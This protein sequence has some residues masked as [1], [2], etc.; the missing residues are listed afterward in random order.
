[1]KKLITAILVLVLVCQ[2]TA[3]AFAAGDAV[4]IRFSWWGDEARHNVTLASIEKFEAAYPNIKIEPE[5]MGWD[6]Y[7]TKLKTQIAGGSAPDVMQTDV[8][9]MPGIVSQGKVFYDL[10]ALQIDRSGFDAKFV[11]NWGTQ[12]GAI[13]GLPTGTNGETSIFNA[14]MM[15]K[16]SIPM[17]QPLSWNDILE[18]GKKLKEQFPDS[19]MML[20]DPNQ[21]EL[22]ILNA[23]ICQ[24]IGTGKYGPGNIRN[25][26]EEDLTEALTYIDELLAAEVLVPFEQSSVHSVNQMENPL[27]LTGKVAMYLNFTTHIASAQKNSP[28]EIA[29]GLF[30]SLEGGK[31]SGIIVQ[32]AQL[33]TISANT[34]HPEEAALFVDFFFNNPDSQVALGLNRSVPAVQS[35]RELLASRGE[36]N[37]VLNEAVNR[38]LAN[39]GETFDVLTYNGEL[40][41]ILVTAVE[42]VGYDT[43]TPAEAAANAIKLIDAKLAEF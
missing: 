31:Q 26:S 19:Y 10:N 29:T 40:V 6:G 35:A 17:D 18:Y 5:Y 2:L 43:M 36:L 34:Q 42:A 8:K 1:M 33:I 13:I 22:H 28:F 27:W 14:E 12:D 3:V 21:V 39:I 41:K 16:A 32:P 23:Y 15:T 30:P 20:L 4:T 38:A 9:E 25:F 7:H 37:P 24:K 11:E